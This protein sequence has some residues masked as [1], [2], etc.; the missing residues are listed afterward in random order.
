MPCTVEVHVRYV[1]SFLPIRENANMVP[2]SRHVCA[3][4]CLRACMHA[5]MSV[6]RE[7]PAL[8]SSNP[9]SFTPVGLY[10]ILVL[11]DRRKEQ[12]LAMTQVLR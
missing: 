9:C 12:C 2:H 10:L 8:C 6:L 3:R 5:C 1:D 11:T 4:L 7:L